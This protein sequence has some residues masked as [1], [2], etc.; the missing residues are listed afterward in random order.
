M[1]AFMHVEGPVMWMLQGRNI[2][3]EQDHPVFSAS[4]IL[5]A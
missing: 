3:L 5:L 4:G 2:V 1:I